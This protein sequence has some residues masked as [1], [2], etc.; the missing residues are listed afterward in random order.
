MTVGSIE[1]KKQTA[2]ATIHRR[3]ISEQEN[4]GA[5]RSK[6]TDI[7]KEISINY[8]KAVVITNSTRLESR[9]K[10]SLEYNTDG[11]MNLILINV[12]YDCKY[13]V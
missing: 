7:L 10:A 3:I 8:F 12:I 5:K 13:F 4:I 11:V 9:A 2:S 1:S 6:Q